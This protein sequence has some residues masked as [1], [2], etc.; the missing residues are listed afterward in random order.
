MKIL[1]ADKFPDKYVKMLKESG[2]E[3]SYEPKLGETIY[4]EV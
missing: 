1:I 3:V 2:H 4:P